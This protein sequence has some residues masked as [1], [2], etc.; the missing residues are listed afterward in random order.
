MSTFLPSP[1]Y[2]NKSNY[3]HMTITNSPLLNDSRLLLAEYSGE[4][5]SAL[6]IANEIGCSE[7]TVLQ[8]LKKYGI[9]IRRAS[10]PTFFFVLENPTF[11][12]DQYW[13]KRKSIP[14]I[15]SE[16]GC[17]P[18]R[19]LCRMQQF[20]IQRRTVSESQK[21]R[22]LPPRS[23]ECRQRMSIARK[24]N[25]PSEDAKKKMSLARKG[26]V[27]SAETRMKMSNALTGRHLSE[28]TKEKLSRIAKERWQDEEYIKMMMNAWASKPNRFEERVNQILQQY[29][30]N[31]W[32]YNGDFSAGVSIG[33]KIPDFVNVNGKKQVI[34]CFGDAFHDGTFAKSWMRS[35]FGIKALY[36]QLGYDC[37]VLWASNC[38][39]M[40]DEAIAEEIKLNAPSMEKSK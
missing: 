4:G 7:H 30:P 38:L 10:R 34:E 14:K 25:H 33:R 17:S 26:R 16:V 24:G 18:E 9:Q 1:L 13:S 40:T 22:K 3:L 6:T 19:V 5:K 11:L 15:A 21:G 39:K 27:V 12:F 32:T 36:S 28:E 37:L 2:S 8:Y 35:E 23:E 29:F 20:G 31:E